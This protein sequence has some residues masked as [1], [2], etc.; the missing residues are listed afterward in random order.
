VDTL[1]Y[2]YCPVCPVSDGVCVLWL[3]NGPLDMKRCSLALWVLC[4][5]SYF[6]SP[7]SN[8]CANIGFVFFFYAALTVQNTRI[9]YWDHTHFSAVVALSLSKCELGRCYEAWLSVDSVVYTSKQ[10]RHVMLVS[11]RS[12]LDVFLLP[13]NLAHI[14]FSDQLCL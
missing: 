6:L 5:C 14:S 7:S 9:Q 13:F 3:H 10:K 4:I 8:S 11:L 12:P 2:S 1:S